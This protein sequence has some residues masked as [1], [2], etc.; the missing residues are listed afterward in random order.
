VPGCVPGLQGTAMRISVGCSEVVTGHVD[1]TP[2]HSVAMALC[3]DA[4]SDVLNYSE[5]WQD[6]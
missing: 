3:A 6:G 5:A 2:K 4:T 1:T